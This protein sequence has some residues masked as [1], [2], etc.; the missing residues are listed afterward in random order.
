MGRSIAAAA[1]EVGQTRKVAF[2]RVLVLLGPGRARAWFSRLRGVSEV[3]REGT[4]G[5]V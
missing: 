3:V 5:K 4:F 1:R 2:E